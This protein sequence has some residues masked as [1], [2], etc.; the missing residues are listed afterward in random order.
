VDKTNPPKKKAVDKT[1]PP[2]KT[3]D[4][5]NPPKKRQWIKQ[6]RQKKGSE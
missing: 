2:K 3:V 1:N 4:K 6:I 5:T